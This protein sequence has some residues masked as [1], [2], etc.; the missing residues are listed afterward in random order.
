M[1]AGAM[2]C[3]TKCVEACMEVGNT[4]N[5]TGLYVHPRMPPRKHALVDITLVCKQ[6]SYSQPQGEDK[7]R[8]SLM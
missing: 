4:K 8:Q 6:W 7:R 5:R 2:Q 1:A 3:G